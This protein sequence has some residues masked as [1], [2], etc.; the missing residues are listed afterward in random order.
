MKKCFYEILQVSRI[1]SEKEIKKNYRKLALKYH[2][3]KNPGCVYSENLIKELNEAYE[4]LIDTN[5]RSL[6]DIQF[7]NKKSFNPAPF[8]YR[9]TEVLNISLTL[10]ESYFSCEKE[11]TYI[12]QH[13]TTK[14]IKIQIPKG[15][16]NGSFL[17]TDN[18][19]M[20]TM[21]VVINMLP[22]KNFTRHGS[23]L[24]YTCDIPYIYTLTGGTINIPLFS[25][26]RTLSIRPNSLQNITIPGFGMPYK[27][28]EGYGDLTIVLKVRG[29]VD[30]DSYIKNEQFA[31]V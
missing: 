6:Y 26:I 24:H 10:E 14:I 15:I 8:Y 30:F 13:G 29:M 19:T 17:V 25:G 9:S 20:H 5:K 3:D 21:R 11:L 16:D 28:G 1:A 7:E 31:T 27:N 2:P 18:E 23:N 12:N 22:H 4:C